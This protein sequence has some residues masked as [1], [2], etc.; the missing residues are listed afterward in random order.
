MFREISI[1]QVMKNSRFMSRTVYKQRN[2]DMVLCYGTFTKILNL[3]KINKRNP[4]Q[5]VLQNKIL[6]S[7]YKSYIDA[8]IPDDTSTKLLQC[9]QGL[10]KD[11]I[12]AARKIV[13]D[14][15]MKSVADHFQKKII[16]AHL[17]KN[18][19]TTRKIIVASLMDI[20]KNDQS[21]SDAT[22]VELVNNITKKDLL[23]KKE[24]ILS[25]FLA[26]IFL[27]TVL[28]VDNNKGK[29]FCKEI[30]G[31]FLSSFFEKIEQLNVKETEDFIKDKSQETGL[32][33]EYES[34]IYEANNALGKAQNWVRVYGWDELEFNSIY[35]IPYLSQMSPHI[36]TNFIISENFD[37]SLSSV[38]DKDYFC[39]NDENSDGDLSS[40]EDEAFFR[41]NE[42]KYDIDLS[43]DEKE[44]SFYVKNTTFKW[45]NFA[46]FHIKNIAYKHVDFEKSIQD[47]LKSSLEAANI[48][49][50]LESIWGSLNLKERMK[51]EKHCEEHWSLE[52]RKE[53]ISK[54]FDDDD[55]IYIV[56]G[57]GYGKSLFLK[58]LCAD[59]NILIDFETNPK[60]IICGDIKRMI[61]SDGSFRS[62]EEF[63]EECFTNG[64]L[65][66]ISD[67]PSN[68][69]KNCLS[70]GRC[71]ILLDAL[72]E[73]G[74][75]QRNKLHNLIV[76]YF[77]AY[78]GNKVCITSRERGFIPCTD[79]KCYYIQP[80]T[81]F[82]VE[83]YVDNFIKL[84]KFNSDEKTDFIGQA[85]GLVEK[86]FIEGFLTLSLLL[87]IYR[88]E[89]ELPTNKLNLYQ[90]CFEYIAT[91]REKNKRLLRNSNTGE[92]Y[93]W[94]ILGRF[95]T[96]A[97]FMGLACLG[98]PNNK[99]ISEEEINKL[100]LDLYERRFD[101]EVECKMATEMFLQFCSD[102]TEI[103]V[104]S[105]NSNFYYRFFHRSFYEYFYAKYIETHTRTVNET[106]D[107]LKIFDID[108][109]IY[110]LLV[111]LYEQRD[112]HYLHELVFKAFENAEEEIDKHEKISQ[113]VDILVM[114]MSVM[115]DKK[116]NQQFIKLFL[117]KGN[118][119]SDLPLKVNFGKIGTILMRDSEFFIEQVYKKQIISKN[120]NKKILEFLCKNKNY[121]DEIIR[122]REKDSSKMSIGDIKDQKGFSFPKLLV[123]LP[124]CYE[125]MDNFFKKYSNRTSLIIEGKMNVT[126]IN[127]V[128]SFSDK[129]VN[130][131]REKRIQIYNDIIFN[132]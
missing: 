73:V 36:N 87:A 53:N 70:Q 78:P 98:T 12:E 122:Q 66:R 102:R 41:D 81:K 126:Q 105:S 88:N 90:K 116:F 49:K 18:D 30:N 96:D 61:R 129:I 63:L 103:F 25:D 57:A 100:M 35:V 51:E 132:A 72:D 131:S 43:A 80:I 115:E 7:V 125:L 48:L 106:L 97:T 59:P 46:D 69:L 83:Q 114:F 9:K 68:F 110:E 108:S 52:K 120:I 127:R 101:N 107:K 58:K 91:S 45:L 109:E 77:G 119:I 17:L 117:E 14:G 79:I 47:S 65:K 121:C 37:V 64:S 11:V 20:I 21:I 94:R 39:D 13:N 19:E 99:D 6:S 3:C 29:N 82:D 33:P 10:P 71:M 4:P 89:E 95:M 75:D 34:L 54:I 15:D 28:D 118:T 22:V 93:D 113:G 124:N 74:N 104:P 85:T 84:K 40:A 123:L 67:L 76:S 23:E 38:G 55:I 50:S 27:F 112:P 24:F 128:L 26:G 62:M 42:E 130:F 5:R 31:D 32:V 44:P 56:G 8:G 2:K 111:T 1:Y 16:G 60:L 86:G 92:E